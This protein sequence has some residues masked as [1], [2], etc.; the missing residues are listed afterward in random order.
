MAEL[1][2]FIQPPNNPELE[3]AVLAAILLEGDCL[4]QVV[5]IIGTDVE[6]F[7]NYK[8]QLIYKAIL[9]CH[10]EGI[11]V[12]MLTV[13]VMLRKMKEL[14]TIGGNKYLADLTL[15]VN[16][17]GNVA[18]H[19]L[20]LLEE[21]MRRFTITFSNEIHG[22]A[23]NY[24]ADVFETTERIKALQDKFE[25]LTNRMK[26]TKTLS[27]VLQSVL[28]QSDKA[29]EAKGMIGVDT[30]LTALNSYTSGWQPATLVIIGARPA[31]G[32][33]ALV[34]RF[35]QAA[36][37]IGKKVLM[38]SVE[39]SNEAIAMRLLSSELKVPTKPIKSGK[40]ER[41]EIEAGV[42]KLESKNSPNL[43][44][45]DTANV[46]IAQ[47]QNLTNKIKPDLIIIDYLQLM[48]VSKQN[49]QEGI[50]DN[51]RAL[52]AI[53]KEHNIP[54]IALSQVNR[55]V[56]KRTD[57]MPKLADLREAG[58]IEQDADMVLFL[59]RPEYWTSTMDGEQYRYL[60]QF[61]ISIAKNREGGVGTIYLEA[62]MAINEVKDLS[63]EHY[64][65]VGYELPQ[66]QS[67]S[68]QMPNIDHFTNLQTLPF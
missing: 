44:L 62:D 7:Y 34:L 36:L 9:N 39:M 58:G 6:A 37:N 2:E 63:L 49:R 17:S 45:D 26:R 27:E 47:V 8:H 67:N 19:C 64:S 48:K 60:N 40:M 4:K 56:E 61:E 43:Y 13:S 12:D 10:I 1:I 53:A 35:I 18:S 15:K 42:S 25:D 65:L 22:L 31:M 29:R 16:S 14:Q 41:Y 66:M 5:S 21:Y 33:T 50:E 52:K 38:F 54:V 32:K 30:G 11:A 68:M 28:V 51:S 20:Y 57:K 59:N 3:Q 55:E 24:S 23:S 46:S